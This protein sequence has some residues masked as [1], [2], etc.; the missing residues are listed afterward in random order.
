MAVRNG[1][2]PEGLCAELLT[3]PRAARGG[4]VLRVVGSHGAAAEAGCRRPTRRISKRRKNVP[5][6]SSG[7]VLYTDRSQK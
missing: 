1:R 4:A 2:L 3:C 6:S 7:T 5:C